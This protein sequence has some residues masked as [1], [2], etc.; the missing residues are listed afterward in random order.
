MVQT[1]KGKPYS[2][3]KN[4]KAETRSRRIGGGRQEEIYGGAEG[5]GWV[6]TSARPKG[7]LQHCKETVERKK[8]FFGCVNGKKRKV[9]YLVGERN[10]FLQTGLVEKALKG[11]THN[12]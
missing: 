1:T 10:S 9:P 11:G 7:L 12:K 4:L 3:I 6:S 8:D 5:G 2:Y